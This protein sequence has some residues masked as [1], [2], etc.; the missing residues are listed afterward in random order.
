MSDTA[1]KRSE[2]LRQVIV[3]LWNWR[4]RYAKQG[5]MGRARLTGKSEAIKKNC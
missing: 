5:L 3:G 2:P 4:F 1:L